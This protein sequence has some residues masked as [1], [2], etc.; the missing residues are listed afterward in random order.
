MRTRKVIAAVFAFA[1]LAV[2]CGDDGDRRFSSGIRDSYLEGCQEAQSAEFCECTIQ[3]I[4][5]LFSEAEFIQ[6]AIEQTEEPPT[7]FIEVAIACIGEAD[8]GG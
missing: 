3:E 7:E 5:E 1:L 2:A 4:E 6:F 8:I